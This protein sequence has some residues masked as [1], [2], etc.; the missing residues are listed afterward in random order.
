MACSTCKKKEKMDQLMNT[1]EHMSKAAIWVLVIW[2]LLGFYGIYSLI[3][4]FI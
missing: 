4:K 3:T 1:G 2:S